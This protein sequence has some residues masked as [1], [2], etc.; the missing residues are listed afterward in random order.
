MVLLL[1]C[2]SAAG[3]PPS[4]RA[5]SAHNKPLQPNRTGYRQ[6]Q[7]ILPAT[8]SRSPGPAQA[9]EARREDSRHQHGP[10]AGDGTASPQVG[11]RGQS[12]SRSAPWSP[13]RLRL[14]ETWEGRQSVPR[15]LPD[16][17]GGVATAFPD[18]VTPQ[19]CGM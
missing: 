12:S 1:P 4:L 6:S 13:R 2:L 8:Q 16:S 19:A 3:L 5:G 7:P 10:A 18:S 14:A 17:P 11:E 15:N 9:A